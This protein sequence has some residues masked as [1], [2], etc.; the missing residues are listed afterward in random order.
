MAA[1]DV[2]EGLLAGLAALDRLTLLVGGQSWLATKLD[3]PRL[4]ACASFARACTNQLVFELVQ[5][6]K[7]GEH[8][9]AAPIAGGDRFALWRP[10]PVYMIM[11]FITYL[12]GGMAVD[13]SAPSILDSSIWSAVIAAI[14]AWAT[15]AG[16][17]RFNREKLRREFQLEF[18]TEAAIQHLLKIDKYTQRSFEKIKHHLRGFA[19][20]E[21]RQHL[22]RAGAVCFTG[23]ENEELWGLLDRNKEEAFK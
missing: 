7:H 23:K 11:S 22:I 2:G 10:P 18:A 13:F 4:G 21:L 6:A 3:A 9:A 15:A 8:V 19:D 5:S 16:T 14:I 17:I 20:N 1:A 12:E